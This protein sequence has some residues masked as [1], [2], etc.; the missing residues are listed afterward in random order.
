MMFLLLHQMNSVVEEAVFEV[1]RM[2]MMTINWRMGN[3]VIVDFGQ[4]KKETLLLLLTLVMPVVVMEIRREMMMLDYFPAVA[5][6]SS[7]CPRHHF[8]LHADLLF[9]GCS[10]CCSFAIRPTRVFAKTCCWL[11]LCCRL[12]YSR[13][14]KGCS[15]G[16]L[17]GTRKSDNANSTLV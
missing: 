1:G 15:C 10:P 9:L 7:S 13:T 17:L 4:V 16:A 14:T 11:L 5:F 8:H 3:A 2:V 6:C 12:V